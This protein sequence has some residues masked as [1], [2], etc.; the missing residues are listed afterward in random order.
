MMMVMAVMMMAVIMVMIVAVAMIVLAQAGESAL[1][2][3]LAVE[4]RF[5]QRARH[6]VARRQLPGQETR[7]AGE[8]DRLIGQRLRALAF[9]QG[10]EIAGRLIEH[11]AE[12][13]THIGRPVGIA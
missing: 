5:E 2:L 1:G 10:T 6:V 9:R 11:P 4:Q 3:V 13:F 12:Q 8:D 7:Q